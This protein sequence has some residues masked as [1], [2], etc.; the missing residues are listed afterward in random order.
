MNE[1]YPPK[2]TTMISKCKG[3]ITKDEIIVMEAYILNVFDFDI[4]IDSTPYTH[5][6]NV[7][8]TIYKDR[9]D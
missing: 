2:I 3:F 1:I 6:V 5:I 7:L 8:G 9:L 4:S